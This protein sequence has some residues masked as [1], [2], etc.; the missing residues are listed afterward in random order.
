[1]TNKLYPIFLKLEKKRVLVIGGGIVALQKVQTLLNT[2]AEII[3]VAPTIV[4]EL[5]AC[6][7]EFPDIRH[8]KFVERE[9]EFGDEEEMH[10][11]IAATDIP[12]LNQQI[13]NR[14]RDQMILVNS[15][16]DPENC[17][18]YVP[19][20]IEADDIKVAISTN[21]KAPAIAQRIRLDLQQTIESKYQACVDLV[22]KFRSAV[23]DKWPAQNEFGR[24]SKLVRW[25]TDRILKRSKEHV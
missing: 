20:V 18:F 10:M 13:A 12:E 5:K 3:V 4:D 16:D 22:V 25:Y 17:D 8:I 24:R 2:E 19:S 21:G 1:M 11:V 23:K 6:R 15:V 14:C 9:Y 7:G